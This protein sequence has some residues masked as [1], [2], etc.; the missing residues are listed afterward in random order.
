MIKP[1]KFRNDFE[2][3]KRIHMF[4]ILFKIGSEMQIKSGNLSIY[5][6]NWL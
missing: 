1:E 5:R 2:C 6:L 4:T 3:S